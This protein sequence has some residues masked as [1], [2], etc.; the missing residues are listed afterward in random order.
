MM[1]WWLVT[2][3]H[4]MKLEFKLGPSCVEHILSMLDFYRYR[5]IYTDSSIGVGIR[6]LVCLFCVVTCLTGTL[7]RSRFAF[8]AYHRTAVFLCECVCG[9][10]W[11]RGRGSQPIES[12]KLW[13]PCCTYLHRLLLSWL[14]L[15]PLSIHSCTLWEMRTI[16]EAFGSF[17]LGKRWMC[18]KLRI[19]LNK[20][21]TQSLSVIF[22]S[23][24]SVHMLCL[25][26]WWSLTLVYIFC[27]FAPYCICGSYETI[28]G[29]ELTHLCCLKWSKLNMSQWFI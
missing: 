13:H 14:R 3:S 12:F 27:G 9:C 11:R 4:S 24:A 17:S 16:E 28:P 26:R 5:F 1:V 7:P 10:V 8:N 20:L 23:W 6:L 21:S 22:L 29:K 15:L 18:H 2:S 19:S 25:E